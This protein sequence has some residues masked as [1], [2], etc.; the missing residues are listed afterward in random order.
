MIRKKITAILFFLTCSVFVY[1]VVP[2]AK[3]VP[4]NPWIGKLIE[5]DSSFFKP[6]RA[7]I[8]LI[9]RQ[10]ININSR[11]TLGQ[12][13]IPVLTVLFAN[14]P[15]ST[16]SS[17]DIEALLFE[18][19]YN[20]GGVPGS[21]RDYYRDISYNM[22]S[23]GGTVYPWVS[24]SQDD[25]YYEGP[26]GCN[27]L[28]PDN[29]VAELLA[30]TI[31]LNDATI[32][33]GAYDNDGPD[34]I[35]NSGD[36][37]G[38]VDTVIFVHADSGGECGS[39]NN[40]W[41]H[42][43]T[44]SNWT[45]IS[46]TTNDDAF[47]GGKIQID[48]YM[49]TPVLSCNSTDLNQIGVFCHEFGHT[50]G[51]V[52]LYDIDDSS[53]GIGSLGLMGHGIWGGDYNSPER[54]V[55]MTAWS[56]SF[57]GWLSPFEVKCDGTYSLKT[58][59]N[60]INSSEN[61]LKVWREGDY[62]GQEYFLISNRQRTGWD[63]LLPLEGVVIEHIDDTIYPDSNNHEGGFDCNG[64]LSLNHFLVAIEEADGDCDLQFPCGSLCEAGD[65]GEESDSFRGDG[66]SNSF[67]GNTIPSSNG[68]DGL[69]TGVKITDISA[70]SATMT[71]NVDVES[72]DV[73]A[74][75][76][77]DSFFTDDSDGNGNGK[78]EP[79]EQNSITVV[80]ANKGAVTATGISAL[81]SSTSSDVAIISSSSAVNDI[82][83]GATGAILTP[84]SVVF[85]ENLSCGD[86]VDFE[87]N[88]TAN[89]GSW[90]DSFSIKLRGGGSCYETAFPAQGDLFQ[91]NKYPY[92]FNV[93][94]M[95]T[96]IRS[97]D[98]SEV[99][100]ADLVL[101]L[102]DNLLANGAN[103]PLSF[104]L[105]DYKIG[106]I[107][108]RSG[109]TTISA[110]FDFPPIRGKNYKIVM[111][112]TSQVPGGQGAIRINTSTSTIT[113]CRTAEE[114]CD[115]VGL[116]PQCSF[117]ATENICLNAPVQFTDMSTGV[118][119]SWFWD[120]GD[121]TGSS[122]VQ[123][124]SYSYSSPGTYTVSLTVSDGDG[125]T[126]CQLP[127]VIK[128]P[129]VSFS[130]PSPFLRGSLLTFTD[131]TT[132]GLT[133]YSYQWDFGDSSS[134]STLQNPS[135]S[136]SINGTYSISLTLTDSDGCAGVATGSVVVADSLLEYADFL[137]DDSSGNNNGYLNPGETATLQ[138]K[139]LN[140][141]IIN[142]SN[143][144]A[145][146]SCFTE[147][148][149][150][151][152]ETA[153]FPDI[154]AGGEAFSL[155]PHFKVST[156]PSV[157][158]GEMIYF[159]LQ[160]NADEGQWVENFSFRTAGPVSVFNDYVVTDTRSVIE[161]LHDS[162]MEEI[163]YLIGPRGIS[164]DGDGYILTDSSA[165]ELV[166]ING[167][168]SVEAVYSGAELS[169][170]MD[171]VV[172]KTGDYIVTNYGNDSIVKV[173]RNGSTASVIAE[174]GLVTG[175]IGI[176]I[177]PDGSYI[178]SDHQSSKILRVEENGNISVIAEADLLQGPMGV[179]V[180]SQGECVAICPSR[181]R[182]VR[183]KEGQPQQLIV[184]SSAF[185][186]PM[187]VD[188][189]S[190]G[191]FILTDRDG[192]K[193]WRV[194]NDGTVSV[195][196][197]EG[198]FQ[199]PGNIAI[200]QIE[201]RSDCDV[202]G[203]APV[204]DFS[205]ISDA[206]CLNENLV[207]NNLSTG[208]PDSWSWDF[209]DG[210]P[211]S[212]ALNPSHLY[213][214]VGSYTVTL[215]VSDYEGTSEQSMNITVL[216]VPSTSFTSNSPVDVGS[217]AEFTSIVSG[218]NSPY[219]FEW[220]F[221]DSSPV[222]TAINPSHL[223]ESTGIYN[224][225]LTVTDNKGCSGFYSESF[226]SG[227]PRLE[228]EDFFIDDTSGNN[229][230]YP[231]PG[232]TVVI[233]ISLK[234]SGVQTAK[235]V[236][237]KLTSSRPDVT[238]ID[239]SAGYP[240][241][242][243]LEVA[244][245]IY[246]HF[247]FNL[248]P[249]VPCGEELIFNIET[250]SNEGSWTDSFKLRI[251]GVVTI[252]ESYGISDSSRFI[253]QPYA[254]TMRD[255]A[256][257]SDPRGIADQNGSYVV[258]DSMANE[259]VR[260]YPDGTKESIFKGEPLSS[261]MDV[262]VD[263]NGNFYVTSFIND[264]IFKITDDGSTIVPVSTGGLIEGPVG[265]D[266]E[267]DGDL[268][269]SDYQSR[270]I[271]RIDNAGNVT[272]L[273]EQGLLA[274]IM[275]IAV[276]EEGNFIFSS[277]LYSRVVN[278]KEGTG[279]TTLA[280]NG[281]IKY[282]VDLEIDS[283]DN[284]IVA[285]RDNGAILQVTPDG[286]VSEIIKGG[287]LT[288]PWGIAVLVE[289]ERGDCDV[290]GFPPKAD[291]SI[292]MSPACIDNLVNFRDNS[293]GKPLSWQWDFGDGTSSSSL[294]PSH[295]YTATGS[296]SVSLT[297]SD[298]EGT[299]I[300]SKTIK[301]TGPPSVSFSSDSP[302][303]LGAT[304]HF[305]SVITGGVSP[306]VFSWDFGDN[307]GISVENNPVYTYE[308][309]G[310]Y[311]ATLEVTDQS[312]CIANYS[313]TVIVGGSRLEYSNSL[314]DDSLG[315]GDG[316]INPGE[317]GFLVVSIAN[318][319]TL[320]ASGISAILSTTD[321]RITIV[322]NY[323][324]FSPLN[325]GTTTD[326]LS[327]HFEI[328]ISPDVPCGESLDFSL[329]IFSDEGSW[330]SI[331]SV[332]AVGFIGFEDFY[333]IATLS[334][335][336]ETSESGNSSELASFQQPRGIMGKPD[337]YVLVDSLAN[338]LI[339]VKKEAETVSA[340]YIFTGMPLLNP[341][342]VVEDER[343]Y[344]IVTS[345][346]TASVVEI[347]PDGSTVNEIASEGIIAGP[348]GIDIEPDGDF[349]VVDYLGDRLIR[350]TSAG[351]VSTIA[352]AGNPFMGPMGIAVIGEGD[353]AVAD[354][355]ARKIY[356]IREGISTEVIADSSVLS[357]PMDLD[358]DR[359]GNLVVPDR[360]AG[361][362]VTLALDGTVVDVISNSLLVKP[363]GI[364]IRTVE[365]RGDCNIFGMPPSALFEADNYSVCL[366][367]T[368]SF[369]DLS[370][371]LPYSWQW[372]FG[373]GSGTSTLTN[374]VYSYQNP[375][376]F[377]VSLTV[378]DSEGWN[379]Y[380]DTITVTSSP[381]VTFSSN[382]PVFQGETVIF[383]SS[384]T[385]GTSPYN[386][387]WNFGDGN[388][389]TEVNPTH[390]YNIF[391]IYTV[392]LTVTDS[393]GCQNSFSANVRVD[394]TAEVAYFDNT[395]Y[396]GAPGPDGTTILGSGNGDHIVNPG[397]TIVM[398]VTLENIGNIEAYSVEASISTEAGGIT[399]IE[400]TG[401][402]GDIP[403]G[404]LANPLPPY[405]KFFV[406]STISCGKKVW[407]NTEITTSDGV[408]NDGFQI[409]IS[410]DSIDID[411]YILLDADVVTNEYAVL[412]I[413]GDGGKLT[414]IFEDVRLYRPMGLAIDDVGNY[415]VTSFNDNKLV[416]IDSNNKMTVI[417]EGTPLDHPYG[418][419][420]DENG[421]YI[422]VS[423]FNDSIIRITPEGEMNIV[424]S[425][426]LIQGPKNV[427]VDNL[428]N[429]IVT[430]FSS[431]SVLK[432]T[433]FGNVS[434]IASGAPFVA[435]TGI[436]INSDGSYVIADP[437][438]QSLFRVTQAGS[439][440][441]LATGDLLVFP[442]NVVAVHSSEYLVTDELNATII[443]VN[444]IQNSME[445]FVNNSEFMTTPVDI[446]IGGY[447]SG[448][449]C[450]VFHQPPIASFYAH[451]N[452]VCVGNVV[453]F[454]DT[455]TGIPAFWEWDFDGDGLTD[456]ID[457]A[458]SYLYSTSGTYSARLTVSDADG[459]NSASRYIRVTENN[460][461]AQFS[462][463][464]PVSEG[465]PLIVANTTSGGSEPLHYLWDFG[466][467]IG[468]STET[469]P[470]YTYSHPGTYTVSLAISDSGDC[471]DYSLSSVVV[472]P[473][474]VLTYE[475][476]KIV[477]ESLSPNNSLDPGEEQ[478]LSI[479][480]GN[481]GS[482][483][484]TGVSVSIALT[485]GTGV[486]VI[487]GTALYLDIEGSSFGEPQP[488]G[489]KIYADPGASEGEEVV[490][491]V[492]I[493]TDQ[494]EVNDTFSIVVGGHLWG[495]L[496]NNFTRSGFTDRM[497]PVSGCSEKKT[498]Y[499][500]SSPSCS[501]VI[502]G[503]GDIF[504]GTADGILHKINKNLEKEWSFAASSSI[505]AT[506]AIGVDGQVYFG[507]EDGKIYAVEKGAF[508]WFYQTTGKILSSPLV[509]PDGTIYAGSMD[510]SMYALNM[511]G[512][513]KWVFNTL[514]SISGAAAVSQNGTIYF[515]S[516]DHRLYAVNSDGTVRWTF[517]TEGRLLS[518][519]AISNG[520]GNIYIGSESGTIYSISP[521]G[522]E[523]WSYSMQ[524]PIL[525]SPSVGNG[526]VVVGNEGGAVFSFSETGEVQWIYTPPVGNSAY[527]IT[528]SPAMDIGGVAYIS[529]QNG[530]LY[531]V[532]ATG[533]LAWQDI[534]SSPNYDISPALHR[535]SRLI[536]AIPE[537]Y[538]ISCEDSSA[539][540]P[541]GDINNDYIVD[542]Q[543]LIIL[544]RAF[545]SVQGVDIS[546][547]NDADLDNNGIIDGEDLAILASNFGRLL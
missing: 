110:S 244:T 314:F 176:D 178:V 487:E 467:G 241:M 40:I 340:E 19:N 300:S 256:V 356:R 537:G 515:G 160:I 34:G 78:P 385:N 139:I 528:S 459:T 321:S 105:N 259:L 510:S 301:I 215:S 439:V 75:L 444:V 250:V 234:N 350:I 389:S 42:S 214:A 411:G 308:D 417:Y 329:N 375:G 263:K 366:G 335:L 207:C 61:C 324:E 328:A 276:R 532:S 223:Y 316:D 318:N 533:E 22:F 87:L 527:V 189:D 412:G 282:P 119:L 29:K 201:V 381:I 14:S 104:K 184:E 441:V 197:E 121:G 203:S 330:E 194:T 231:S 6:E 145:T 118:P 448:E 479:V 442:S 251:S 174:G 415:I 543:D 499:L 445:I 347:S 247:S 521:E 509:G 255:L 298:T 426:G 30:E 77:I 124:P 99:D 512:S 168:G 154:V 138:V 491:S 285:D 525:S 224:V 80:L 210:S 63:L 355:L 313:D 102:S 466:D 516:H 216:S 177:E 336:V 497:G 344:Y 292:S 151:Q 503:K 41:S 21:M 38:Y 501:P 162:T 239:D 481:N 425:G 360:V 226:V 46:Y 436:D 475:G 222:S 144:T 202:F 91:L 304:I 338:S 393:N 112:E 433:P 513:I 28:C 413:S 106:A 464:S 463:N 382:S 447:I 131:T 24:A 188:I 156:D 450:D 103:L 125:S 182:L 307:S 359:H 362:L 72:C 245:S 453:T 511:D 242:D 454:E 496:R 302:V 291:F 364:G 523:N 502:N 429:Y 27:G 517:P 283:S 141:S 392:T 457:N 405:Y 127:L 299:D 434:I 306:F 73:N 483:T 446:E 76:N 371:G 279:A 152:N 115:T 5:K 232:E 418:V 56:K 267:P 74:Y 221:G 181:R 278:F 32:D 55:Q 456:S 257:L 452:P 44:Y 427:V 339:R 489:F 406:S 248:A 284:C 159:S 374:P 100:H 140:N 69:P 288:A 238:I 507:T 369:T 522:T 404:A 305:S 108:V 423:F 403:I 16:Y 150:I 148:V 233:S 379:K 98:L 163:A 541:F 461:N 198:L 173:S 408:I 157:P 33:F 488:P 68:N 20:T 485:S 370:S 48:D 97:S 428:G 93:R 262:V 545:G 365:N 363:W 518:A 380:I 111:A 209:G 343:G 377:S 89:E 390:L 66:S 129:Y 9:K 295:T 270:S 536:S 317:S 325:P 235:G 4:E 451:P 398:L 478:E 196:L 472:Q 191:E 473:S 94:D 193:L 470:V 524:L 310:I 167:D 289:E 52:D 386:Y 243:P 540:S 420:I 230:G 147:G 352:V 8:N 86:I 547:Y 205:V 101:N 309:A 7:F 229:D 155:P 153:S 271:L 114:D 520:T 109:Q 37:D 132:G 185:S 468:S 57:L 529:I 319:G 443:Q 402:Y 372:D 206:V 275:Y 133:P 53:N 13:N 252:M 394:P 407:F 419:D 3:N 449:D 220:D 531:A 421:N 320:P 142:T 143:I 391:G 455:S 134:E 45:G 268:I 47:S 530:G 15:A 266:I 506:P 474:P 269:V 462:T 122:V 396:D 264:S 254:D 432:I 54:P 236:F 246:P 383:S 39:N 341:K 437:Q 422:V 333:G 260:I 500:N 435:P 12:R 92:W 227:R 337:G 62:S 50:L 217:L 35:P 130:N 492:T 323:A 10:K 315:T 332:R 395:I 179:A 253:E 190:N 128:G 277:P 400:E 414:R 265:I 123:H 79:G 170:P 322:D 410:G 70:S 166:R 59:S 187:D 357:Y 137:I 505:S 296:Y 471:Q 544:S 274:G 534:S 60:P 169:G 82:D 526:R 23:V 458:P 146:L 287:L 384:L 514:D 387:N 368:V 36:D 213:S 354:P 294:N 342:D 136:Y 31:S 460:I 165:D 208:L 204:A 58:F 228:F 493:T 1:A 346:N 424:A 376:T 281:L 469:N 2:S 538:I 273:A 539:T 280:E 416:K 378:S 126:N 107:L 83:S 225:Q 430:D 240:D 164:I 272:K 158:C 120:F 171:V 84:F 90:N 345:Y 290:F 261:P 293:T 349:I 116:S 535:N 297:V 65:F 183:I 96:G 249:S 211:A 71:M 218:G 43:S 546:F 219:T 331:F 67:T 476:V 11:A 311:S 508:R 367:E 117:T 542:G 504:I 351:V 388:S 399:V 172:D 498:L 303:E 409:I 334:K 85:S 519:P 95:V 175:P 286:T 180:I 401:G 484:A 258:V 482:A 477:A 186:Y 237:A 440:T 373:D 358:F 26:A 81:L 192:S 161:I 135:Y 494:S 88:I 200:R 49:I 495:M 465:S 113:L 312:G 51:L 361:V 25:S 17:A 438:A 348:I 327:P 195:E 149:S 397:E 480:V 212:T 490:F 353:F 486:T 18:D 64:N 199:S 326:S 431:A